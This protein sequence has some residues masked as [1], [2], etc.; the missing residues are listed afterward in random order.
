M[1]SEHKVSIP[2]LVGLVW[3]TVGGRECARQLERATRRC[4]RSALRCV[5]DTLHSGD[6]ATTRVGGGAFELSAYGATVSEQRRLELGGSLEWYHAACGVLPAPAVS[7]VAAAAA[8]DVLSAALMAVPIAL[9]TGALGRNRGSAHALRRC[10]AAA[11]SATAARESEQLGMA[12]AVELPVLHATPA[13]K[14]PGV[15]GIAVKIA[16]VEASL[17][18]VELALR[19]SSSV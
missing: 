2:M 17:E 4:M 6:A 19:T 8:L 18:L 12:A 3:E 1:R 16:A 11:A 14:S 10:A 13:G 7:S 5:R 9:A 15:D